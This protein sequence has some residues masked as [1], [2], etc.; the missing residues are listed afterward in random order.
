M[1]NLYFILL[2]TALCSCSSEPDTE[3]R[4]AQDLALSLKSYQE[5]LPKA[6]KGEWRYTRKEESQSIEEYITNTPVQADSLRTRLYLQLLD[7]P[8]SQQGQLIYQLEIYLSEFFQVELV[9]VNDTSTLNQ[10]SSIAKRVYF[11]K[12]QL[13]SKHII[14]HHLEPN[15]P[16]DAIGVMGLTIEDLFPDPEWDFVFGQTSLHHRAGITSTNMLQSNS[17]STFLRIS[18]TIDS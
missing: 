4:N 14:Y 3:I 17:D 10:I 9:V 18:R 8:I 2:L 1:K 13:H 11:D 6:N 16:G 12:H 5:K 15:L 7:F